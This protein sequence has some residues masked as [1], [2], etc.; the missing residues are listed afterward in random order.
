M[1]NP[2][3][4]GIPGVLDSAEN[5]TRALDAALRDPRVHKHVD[6]TRDGLRRFFE[7]LDT[8]FDGSIQV[9]ELH[10]GF[11]RTLNDFG[12]WD[13]SSPEFQ[14]FWE[15]TWQL[16][17][18]ELA[19][20]R[21]PLEEESGTGEGPA[22]AD[23]VG[24]ID[25]GAVAEAEA[26][27]QTPFCFE[28]FSGLLRR[29][30]LELALRA[31]DEKGTKDCPLPMLKSIVKIDID[32]PGQGQGRRSS[33]QLEEE[34]VVLKTYMWNARDVHG[35]DVTRR[36]MREFFLTSRAPQWAMRWIIADSA[37][38][39]NIVRL[40]V[41]YRFHPL[42]LEDVLKL[43][44]QQPRF[45]RY[46]GHYL[47]ILPLLRL[48]PDEQGNRTAAV[49]GEEEDGRSSY[50]QP[51]ASQ[52]QQQQAAAAQQ[53]LPSSQ[54][55]QQ[56]QQRVQHA[57]IHME[58]S[59]VAI[60]AAGPPNFD[61]IISI[62]GAWRV[63]R[64]RCAVRRGHGGGSGT[65]GDGDGEGGGGGGGSQVK[66]G[67]WELTA[68]ANNEGTHDTFLTPSVAL[69][70]EGQHR[71]SLSASSKAQSEDMILTGATNL[72]E[73]AAADAPSSVLTAAA[74]LLH[75]DYSSVRQGNSNWMLHA[76]IETTA[77]MLVRGGSSRIRMPVYR[78]D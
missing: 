59:R 19:S 8:N 35:M 70:V 69:P 61:T 26:E 66:K 57:G 14:A 22:P 32:R 63:V 30:K 9:A 7:A 45:L 48:I 13:D 6:V 23:A 77:K 67:T 24:E 75:E 2:N 46:G 12:L 18:E 21:R 39:A 73:A 37:D 55:Q 58:K 29:L 31:L 17:L 1:I 50:A 40:A 20:L 62:H 4:S 65:G 51:R 78:F 10:E 41:K 72:D 34:E 52:A 64:N 54:Q 28:A 42:H 38:R 5:A 56:Q 33:I 27:V 16:M 76:M 36:H 53:P 25:R 71:R 74:A 11:Q 60:F 15:E 43:D 47:I 44:R 3:Q 49:G 68:A